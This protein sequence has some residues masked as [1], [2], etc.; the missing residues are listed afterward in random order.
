MKVFVH[1]WWY[2]AEFLLEWEMFQTEVVEKVK[3]HNFVFSNSLPPKF[4][5]FVR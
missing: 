5:P 1:L 2:L 4:V 3:T